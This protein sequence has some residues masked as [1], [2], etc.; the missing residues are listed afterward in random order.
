MSGSRWGCR[1]PPLASQ[2]PCARAGA[3]LWA[4]PSD[5]KPQTIVLFEPSNQVRLRWRLLRF[6]TVG[7]YLRFGQMLMNGGLLDGQRVLSPKTVA[8]HDV[9]SLG[10]RNR[11]QRRNVEPHR[12]GF[13]FGL[14]VA[15]AHPRGPVRRA[16]QMLANTPG[17][18]PT[19]P[20][21]SPIRAK[22]W[23]S[24]SGPRHPVNCANITAS[25]CKPSSMR[26]V[27]R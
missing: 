19:G 13:G 15:G 26:P 6:S 2:S 7:D 20:P 1:T 5:G 16:G 4:N 14:G 24:C 18:G 22:S 9:Q 27:T 25:R 12:E 17:M 11:E 23:W 10:P 8:A 3:A 21:S